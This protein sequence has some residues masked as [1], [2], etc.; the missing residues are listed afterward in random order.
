MTIRQRY[1]QDG[2]VSPIE[3]LDAAEAREVRGAFDAIESTFD[4]AARSTGML[5]LHL[6]HEPLW[7]LATHRR[8]LDAASEALGPDLI[9][10][11]THFF[12]KYPGQVEAFVAWH[13]DATYWGL[14]PAVAITGWIAIDDA[15]A[16]NGCMRVIPGSHR[17]GLMEH[18]T[19]KQAGNLLSVNQSL[20]LA[21]GDEAIAVD[22]ELKAGQ[23]SLHDGL[24]IHGSNPNRSN[25]RR[26][27]FTVR[28][29]RPDVQ[30]VGNARH[31]HSWKPMLVRGQDRFNHF[32]LLAHPFAQRA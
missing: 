2:F 24:L 30:L 11:G 27:G 9:L 22:S 17:R 12:V 5:H 1:E 25:R 16:E 18:G 26:A 4:P 28:L 20:E 8:L 21:T 19:A 31:K 3:V 32:Q 15:D 29:T 23:A 10:L 13:Q 14:D 6:Q 7:R